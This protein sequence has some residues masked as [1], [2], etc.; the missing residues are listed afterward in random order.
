VTTWTAARAPLPA[1]A[2]HT[3]A[4]L[5]SVACPSAP[6]CTAVG[7]AVPPYRQLAGILQDQIASGELAPG[8]AVRG[9]REGRSRP[10]SCRRAWTGVN[11]PAH[12]V[13]TSPVTPS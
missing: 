13:W 8:A 4:Q 1:N 10:A 2:D 11:S 6:A 12:A 5:S 3:F 9:Q 7:S